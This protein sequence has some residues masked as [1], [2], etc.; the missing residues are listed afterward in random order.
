MFHIFVSSSFAVDRFTFVQLY[1]RG[2]NFRLVKQHNTVNCY[3]NSFVGRTVNAWNS[4]WD[5]ILCS[6]YVQ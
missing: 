1:I 4:F 5:I 2:H 6:V 3:L